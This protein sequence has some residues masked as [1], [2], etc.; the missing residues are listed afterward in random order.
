MLNNLCMHA[1]IIG[2]RIILFGSKGNNLNLF[3]FELIESNL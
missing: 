2:K 3:K 1:C